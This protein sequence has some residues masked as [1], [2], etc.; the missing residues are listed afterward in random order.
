MTLEESLEACLNADIAEVILEHEKQDSRLFYVDSFTFLL[1]LQIPP[2][3][4][5]LCTRWH[6]LFELFQ[7]SP[8]LW[9]LYIYSHAAEGVL[10]VLH[11]MPE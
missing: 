3:S 5:F 11:Q 7:M 9:D 6:P 8:S 1:G 2:G 10:A 4:A